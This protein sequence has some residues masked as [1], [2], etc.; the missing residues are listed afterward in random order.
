MKCEMLLGL[1]WLNVTVSVE[2][3]HQIYLHNS[4]QGRAEL[5]SAILEVGTDVRRATRPNTQEFPVLAAYL[6]MVHPEA[7]VRMPIV[8][9]IQ[10]LSKQV[11]HRDWDGKHCKCSMSVLA[12]YNCP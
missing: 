1:H 8:L 9:C 10:K 5:L 4:S 11:C 3:E 2:L 12:E 6:I 7:S